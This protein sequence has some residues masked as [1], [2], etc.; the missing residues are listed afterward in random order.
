[1]NDLCVII[2]SLN[3]GGGAE[4]VIAL[5]LNS[6]L[7]KNKLKIVYVFT[8]DPTSENTHYLG[9]RCIVIPLITSYVKWR[10]F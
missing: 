10:F 2:N 9:D 3:T 7:K 5:V 4:R 6:L 8:L 1:M